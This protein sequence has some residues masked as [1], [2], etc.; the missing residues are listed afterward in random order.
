MMLIHRKKKENNDNHSMRTICT[1][2]DVVQD[3]PA[4]DGHQVHKK[5]Q[6]DKQQQNCKCQQ[7]KQ[8][9]KINWYEETATN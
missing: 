2:C 3:Q 5:N 9:Q 7:Q 8:R 6:Q 1:S 4:N